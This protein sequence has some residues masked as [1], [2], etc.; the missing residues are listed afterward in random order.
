M[1][2]TREQNIERMRRLRASDP[3]WNR[4]KNARWKAKNHEKYLAHKKVETALKAGSLK[5]QPC[6][7]CGAADLVHAHHDD[8]GRP[9][10]VTWLCPKHHRERHRELGPNGAAFSA[11]AEPRRPSRLGLPSK[12]FGEAHNRA[13]L[14]DAQVLDIRASDTP[15]RAIARAL[16]VSA[17]TIDQIRRGKTWRHLLPAAEGA[18]APNS[19]APA[20]AGAAIFPGGR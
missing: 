15:A 9:L 11:L 16:G 17:A 7:R 14:T 13:R 4:A 12:Q 2:E 10:A 20:P 6:E 19:A 5:R 3:E 8:Y 18:H 1:P